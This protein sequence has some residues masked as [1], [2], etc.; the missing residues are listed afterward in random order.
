MNGSCRTDVY[1][2][3]LGEGRSSWKLTELQN[4][5][6]DIELVMR[7]MR[8]QDRAERKAREA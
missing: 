4:H 3:D 7:R 6:K 1:C 2:C 8:Q 5:I